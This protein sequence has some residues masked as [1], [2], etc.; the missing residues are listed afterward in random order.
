MWIKVEDRKPK[1]QP[2]RSRR[3]YMAYAPEYGG[4]IF[5][6][7]Y[8]NGF[9]AIGPQSMIDGVTHYRVGGRGEKDKQ[10]TDK[11]FSELL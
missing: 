8:R 10:L 9:G 2:I 7:W 3:Y 6:C 11:E 5:K 1:N 4:Y